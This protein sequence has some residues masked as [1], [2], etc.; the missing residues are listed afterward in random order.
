MPPGPRRSAAVRRGSSR[1]RKLVW[2]TANGSFA[3]LAAGATGGNDLLGNLRTAGSSILGATVIRTHLRLSLL[4]GAGASDFWHVGLIVCRDVDI[5][6]GIDPNTNPGDNWLLSVQEFPRSSGATIDAQ[7]Q[8]TYD[9]RAK[10]R[11]EELEERYGLFVANHT[12]AAHNVLF[13]A[14]TLVALA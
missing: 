14:R 11:V 5:A 6:A 1:R 8:M 12:A 13:Y 9:I 10:R 2:A 7:T 4:W 3:A